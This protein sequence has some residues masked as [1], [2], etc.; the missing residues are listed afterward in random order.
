MMACVLPAQ[1]TQIASTANPMAIET[2]IAGTAQVAAQQTE[3]AATPTSVPT[4]I[5]ATVT[6]MP[7]ISPVTGTSL[8]VNEDQSTLFTD[9]K[10]GIQLTI[11]SGWLAVRVNEDEYYKAF[12]LDAVLASP[13]ITDSLTKL[14]NENSD[15]LRLD[16]IDIRPGHVYGGA[17]SGVSV[18]FEQDDFR[19]LEQW[20]TA[21][22]KRVSISKGYKFLS[23]K[24][25]QTA[26]GTNVLVI[27]ATWD[28][29]C[30]AAGKV[31]YTGVFFSLPTGTVV[32]DFYTHLDFKE[33]VFPDFEKVVNSLTL[34]S[35]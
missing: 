31:D 24:I 32:L 11:P 14:A 3:Q 18:I 1:T 22:K 26:N 25:Q 7:Q 30:A 17:I 16:A 9:H 33:T 12:A 29:N 23:S 35:Q 10:A 13:D 15:F 4:S 28:C 6:L 21:E 5:P 27:E 8:V 2:F 34:I 19:T 20:A